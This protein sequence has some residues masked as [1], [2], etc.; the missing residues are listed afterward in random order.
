MADD[1]R[2]EIVAEQAAA[3]ARRLARE[4]AEAQ[5][6]LDRFVIQAKENL[7]VQQLRA[8]SFDGRRTY[9]TRV[10]G[11]YLPRDR[12]LGVDTEGRFY[13]LNAVGGLRERLRGVT[14]EPSDPPLAVGRGARDGESM[15]LAELLERRL[16]AGDSWS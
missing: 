1:A 7:T 11:W 9:A 4:A 16:A 14:V 2:D 15:S 12:S 13:I 8:R 6:M 10:V 3:H 5:G